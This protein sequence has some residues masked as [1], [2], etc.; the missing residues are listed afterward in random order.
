MVFHPPHFDPNSKQMSLRLWLPAAALYTKQSRTDR[1]DLRWVT[2]AE[3]DHEAS[4]LPELFLDAIP[5]LSL[6][7][8]NRLLMGFRLG[9]GFES[10]AKRIDDD[11]EHRRKN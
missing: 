5:P 9:S 1:C 6:D 7:R 8:T 4:L 2:L 10:L 11:V 3:S